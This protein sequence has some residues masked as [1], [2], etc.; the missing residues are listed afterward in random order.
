MKRYVRDL[1]KICFDMTTRTD[2]KHTGLLYF[3]SRREAEAMMREIS[4]PA[5]SLR[6]MA[7][8]DQGGKTDH[9]VQVI[10]TEGYPR[11]DQEKMQLRLDRIELG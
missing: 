11:T 1:K 6:Y 7:W 8:K 3:E 9:I 4:H 10:P 2:N 5:F